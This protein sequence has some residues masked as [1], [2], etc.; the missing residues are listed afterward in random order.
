[1]N[2]FFYSLTP[3][4]YFEYPQQSKFESEVKERT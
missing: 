4:L 2:L 3:K 1:M